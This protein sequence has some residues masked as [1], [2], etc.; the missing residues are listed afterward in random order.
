MS[1][2]SLI[3]KVSEEGCVYR[4]GFFVDAAFAVV[5]MRRVKND[6][7]VC[8][9]DGGGDNTITMIRAMAIDNYLSKFMGLRRKRCRSYGV[10]NSHDG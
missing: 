4:P 7:S 1:V 6:P 9:E 3:S 5:L 2:V 8:L 10:K